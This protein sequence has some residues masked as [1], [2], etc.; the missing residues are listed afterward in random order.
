M[1]EKEQA[2]FDLIKIDVEGFELDVFAGCKTAL[3]PAP[4]IAL[5]IH[6]EGLRSRSQ[7]VADISRLIDVDRY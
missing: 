5:E 2:P 3:L 1:L 7:S 6:M 4:K